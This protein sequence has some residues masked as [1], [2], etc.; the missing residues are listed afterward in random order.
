MNTERKQ[1]QDPGQTSQKLLRLIPSDWGLWR[2]DRVWA[3]ERM[4]FSRTLRRLSACFAFFFCFGQTILLAQTPDDS[5]ELPKKTTQYVWPPAPDLPRIAYVRSLSHPSELGMETRRKRGFFDWLIGRSKLEH[6]LSKPFGIAIDEAN[7]ICIT[8][9][10]TRGVWFYNFRHNRYDF[11]DKIG[12]IHLVSPVA[13][14]KN[15]SRFYVADSELG[16]VLAFNE[17]AE[18]LKAI[19][20][21]LTRPS[22]LAIS[23]DKL[24]VADSEMHSILVF[25]LDG[26]LL[27]SFGKRGV[28]SG[29]FNY[30]T[31]LCIAPGKRLFVT[32]SMNGRVQV[33]DLEGTFLSEIG[34]LGDGSGHLSRPKGVAADKLGHVYVVDALFDNFQIFDQ[35]GQFLLN[36]GEAGNRPGEFWMPAGIAI[37]SENRIYVVDSYNQRIQEFEYIDQS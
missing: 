8:D 23:G 10:G 18:L 11:W 25:D 16:M 27:Y 7:N 33:F 26:T 6:K 15:G 17:K 36:V 28:E 24:F 19:S 12:S 2:Y 32:D 31:H 21:E 20:Q 9:T 5:L 3:H 29:E 34:Q 30:P 37:S 22:G 1:S 35:Q 14:A 4:R 13:I